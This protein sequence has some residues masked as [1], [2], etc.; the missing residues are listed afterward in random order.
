MGKNNNKANDAWQVFRIQGE[1]VKGFDQLSELGPC[2]SIFGSARTKKDN[3]YY[4]NAKELA[5][6]DG[7]EDPLFLKDIIDDLTRK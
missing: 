3:K 6:N 2:I 1:F 7:S 5:L 4:N